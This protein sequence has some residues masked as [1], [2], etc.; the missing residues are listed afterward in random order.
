M[1]K[2][3]GLFSGGLDSML[4]VKLMKEQGIGVD[5]LQ[6][7]LG[8]EPLRMRRLTKNQERA[9]T[10]DA[11]EQ[12]LG[13]KIHHP[14]VREEFLQLV[15][16]PKYGY[17]SAINP[18]IDC[19]MF[20]LHKAKAYMEAHGAHFVF[21]GEVLGQR[22]MSQHRQTLLQTE[23][24]A[25]L[26][27]YLLRPLS[28][29][30]LEPTIPEQQGW[31]DREKLFNISGRGRAVQTELAEK[32]HLQYPQ[33]AGGCLLTDKMFARRF[34]E[35]MAYK[36]HE[37]ISIEDVELLKLGR[38]FRLSE[39]LKVI[40]G[41]HQID[42]NFLQ[43]HTSGRWYAHVREYQG[44]LVL[45]DGIPSEP[46]CEQIAQIAVKYTKGKHADHVTVDFYREG[47]QHSVSI[48]PNPTCI[49]GQWQIE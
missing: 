23:K 37:Q 29:K 43:Q 48:I 47:E 11:I 19:K 12:Q 35:L 1:I 8:F 24:A 4:A 44:P 38:H 13:V 30:L 25:G 14:D 27:G 49:R 9:V 15:F 39:T 17:G 2:A 32:Y 40:V 31:V 34:Q 3:V 21:T 5:V 7:R 42:N 18:C 45:I 10:E 33:P 46:Q 28:A 20:I 16:N 41:R 26:Q 6:Y 36:P 22:P